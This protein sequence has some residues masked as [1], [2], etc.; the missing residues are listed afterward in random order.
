MT[1]RTITYVYVVYVLHYNSKKL[2]V[3]SSSSF[4]Q[5]LGNSDAIKYYDNRYL[6]LFKPKVLHSLHIIKSMFCVSVVL[7]FGEGKL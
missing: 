3:K 6:L 5:L 7:F 2:W 1:V 4:S